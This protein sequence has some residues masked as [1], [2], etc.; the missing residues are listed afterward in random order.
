MPTTPDEIYVEFGDSVAGGFVLPP[1]ESQ[2][3]QVA[4]STVLK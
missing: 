4:T 3:L 2:H 1:M